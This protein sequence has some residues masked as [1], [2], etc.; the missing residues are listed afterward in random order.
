ML[1]VLALEPEWELWLELAL[2]L[3][4]AVETLDLEMFSELVLELVL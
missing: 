4:W 2:V 3:Q 1:H